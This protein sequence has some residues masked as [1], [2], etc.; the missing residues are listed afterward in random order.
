MISGVP[1]LF[2]VYKIL[3]GYRALNRQVIDANGHFSQTQ[4]I[5]IIEAVTN[6]VVSIAMVHCWGICGILAGTVISLLIG[7]TLYTHYLGKNVAPNA[8]KSQLI[9]IIVSMPV[10]LLVFL[11]GNSMRVL[12]I[13]WVQC[14]LFSVAVGVAVFL[15]YGTI[16]LIFSHLKQ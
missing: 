2:F 11:L 14:F 9:M 15:G 1:E 6:I 3:Y 10:L 4:M 13:S 12:P 5:P 7:L 8:I 16:Y